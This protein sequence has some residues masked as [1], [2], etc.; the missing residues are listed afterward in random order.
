M[1]VSDGL[2]SFIVLYILLKS[3]E[4]GGV[5]SH[6]KSTMWASISSEAPLYS[7]YVG[8]NIALVGCFPV[9]VTRRYALAS[10]CII[11]VD[12]FPARTN[13]GSTLVWDAIASRNCKHS[14]SGYLDISVF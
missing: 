7:P 13:E 1:N 5:G 2:C 8:V 12:P 10:K 4:N 11:S 14:G 9:F 6:G 3:H